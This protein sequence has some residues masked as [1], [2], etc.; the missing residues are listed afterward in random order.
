MDGAQARAQP[1]PSPLSRTISSLLTPLPS[2]PPGPT[3]TPAPTGTPIS[4]L[5]V[6]TRITDRSWVQVWA[7][8]KSVLAQTLASETT[9]TFNAD[10]SVRMRVGNAGGVDITVNGVHQGRLGSIG[11]VLDASWGRD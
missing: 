9:R 2:P 1:L 5:L 6:E 4:G 3:E 7:D 10:Q 11:Q 8:G